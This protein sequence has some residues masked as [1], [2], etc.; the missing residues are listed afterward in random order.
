MDFSGIKGVLEEKGYKVTCFDTREEACRYLDEQID[1]TSVGFGGSVTLSEMGIYERLC[2]HNTVYW[3][4]RPHENMSDKEVRAAENR[5]KVYVSSMNALAETGE[6]VNNDATGNR[7]ASLFYGHEKVYLVA[8]ENKICPD[9]EHAVWRARNIASPRNAKRLGRK[10]PCAVRADRCYDCKSPERICRGLA[11]LWE[12]M[13]G[14]D[15]EVVL[16]HENLGY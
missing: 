12:N 15:T 1:G 4:Q 2:T 13:L 7:V 11:V 6:I 16:I 5:A 10:T 14:Q 9:Y 3:H 8:G